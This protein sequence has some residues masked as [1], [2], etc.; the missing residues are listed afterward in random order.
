MV[1]LTATSRTMVEYIMRGF[2]YLKHTHPMWWALR[3]DNFLT[4]PAEKHKA[5]GGTRGDAHKLAYVSTSA[6]STAPRRGAQE[7]ERGGQRTS[8]HSQARTPPQGSHKAQGR[9]RFTVTPPQYHHFLGVRGTAQ[10][11]QGFHGNAQ[12]SYSFF[13][14]VSR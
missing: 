1:S 4:L 7:A 2:K 11:E 14:R 5:G 9:W 6:W 12:T 8:V 3:K 13:F 10:H